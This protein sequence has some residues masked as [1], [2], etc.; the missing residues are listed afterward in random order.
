MIC[1]EGFETFLASSYPQLDRKWEEPPIDPPDWYLTIG[2]TRY[3]VE[4][5]S[6]TEHLSVGQVDPVPSPAVMTS[7]A[8]FVDEIEQTALDQEILSGAY[9]VSLAPI[10]NLREHKKVLLSRFLD[11]ISDTQGVLSAPE[12]SLGYIHDNRISIVK[13]HSESKY[14]AEMI[15]GGVK[16]GHDAQIELE[17]YLAEAIATKMGKLQGISDP[18]VLLILDAYHYSHLADWRRAI[19]GIPT[20]Q[21]FQ[22]IA[23]VSPSAEASVV[24]PSNEWLEA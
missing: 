16:S 6:I 13:M 15:S 23:R 11:Y 19:V 10:P 1:R 12:K 3:A 18:L 14:V 21:A 17:A 20:K 24:W 5:T 9:L 7:L 22:A 2:D 8:D 4:A